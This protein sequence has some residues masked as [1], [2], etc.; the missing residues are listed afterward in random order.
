MSRRESESRL[1]FVD[2]QIDRDPDRLR[3]QAATALERGLGYVDRE[4]D[5]LARLRARVALEAAPREELVAAVEAQQADDGT[6][7]PLGLAATGAWGAAPVPSAVLGALEA[8]SILSDVDA[9]HA[10]CVERCARQLEATQSDDGSWG[11]EGDAPEDCIFATGLLGGLLARTRYARP[12]TLDAA[13][14]FLD[15]HWS[16]KAVVEGGWELL[17]ASSVFFGNV[18]GERSEA[19]SSWCGR[20]LERRYREGTLGALPVLR[21]LMYRN[22]LSVPGA[23]FEPIDLLASLLPTQTEA[24]AFP[25][26]AGPGVAPTVDALR[27]IPVLC[28]AF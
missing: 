6:F 7:A 12:A 1:T 3:E 10:E 18:A 8:L 5:A 27:S 11:G 4:G 20:D 16:P 23:G 22:A 9:L 26:L 28:S 13:S 15:L 21:I 19:V 25:G 2:L 14:R 24:G 17:A